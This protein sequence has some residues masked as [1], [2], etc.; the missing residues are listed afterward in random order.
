MTM[1][2]PATTPWVP[3][4]EQFG[5][6]L[7]MIRHEMGWNLK[8]AAVECGLS[9]NAW[10]RYEDGMSPRNLIQVVGLISARTGVDRTW[11][12]F[13]ESE[14]PRPPRRP[15]GFLLPDLDSNQEPAANTPAASRR[16]RL[17]TD[18]RMPRPVVV[19]PRSQCA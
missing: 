12:T 5:T 7:A 13:G 1:H 18:Q 17:V 3:N 9:M 2:I 4:T 11:L 16:L 10:A 19:L 6:R 14:S 8:E 15:E